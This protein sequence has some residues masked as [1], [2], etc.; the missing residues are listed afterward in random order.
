MFF[1]SV[2]FSLLTFRGIGIYNGKRRKWALDFLSWSAAVLTL[3][4]RVYLGYHT[5]GQ[6]FAGAGLGTVLG[7]LWFWIVNNWLYLYFPMIEESV[8][9]RMFY[10]KDTSHIPN[11][12]KFEYD[13]ARAARRD[14][15]AAKAN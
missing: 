5:V 8:L 4:S 12:L 9:G 3:Y 1:F 10:V 14:M 13:N 15:D 11:V 6:V 2:Y 7:G